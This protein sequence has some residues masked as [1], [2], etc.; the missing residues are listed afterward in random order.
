M[1][2]EKSSSPRNQRASR[3]HQ[4]KSASFR[5]DGFQRADLQ[6]TMRD[7]PRCNKRGHALTCSSDH[8]SFVH[9]SRWIF[10]GT[11][12][13]AAVTEASA[14]RATFGVDANLVNRP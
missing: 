1:R 14:I 12:G 6:L 10:Q 11:A 13:S 8:T 2:T 3:F 7:I 9:Q 4:F 5:S